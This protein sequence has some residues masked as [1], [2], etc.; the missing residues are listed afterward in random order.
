MN[1]RLFAVCG[2]AVLLVVGSGGAVAS[3]F[4]SGPGPGFG[5]DNA[6]GNGAAPGEAPASP[7]DNGGGDSGGDDE[8]TD[9]PAFTV[10]ADNTE[11]CGRTCRDVM[12]TVTNQQNA[13]AEDVTV[14]TQIFAGK[15][16]NGRQVW[17][18]SADVGT[19][20]GGESHTATK[21][22][23]LGFGDAVAVTGAGG[24]VTIETTVESDEETVTITERRDVA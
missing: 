5:P 3:G 10:V 19:L 11:K 6:P 12:S 13:T 1:A 21:R 7:P 20:A 4:G 15:E 16:G 24:W 23:E 2:I 22:I 8:T 17:Q 14:S 18:G 9:E